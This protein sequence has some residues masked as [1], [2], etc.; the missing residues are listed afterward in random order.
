MATPVRSGSGLGGR[1]GSG[2]G[3]GA[4]AISA[5]LSKLES[6]INAEAEGRILRAAGL[7]AKSAALSAAED[8]LGGDRAMSNYK[9]GSVALNAGFDTK[10]WQLDINH[11]P[12]GLWLLADEGRKRSGAIYPRRNGR[13]ARKATKGRAVLTP[14][15]PRA[16]SSFKPSRGTNVFKTASARERDKASEAAWQALQGEIR[17]IVRG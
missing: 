6:T 3:F 7:A 11:R 2:A 4:S 5:Y 1:A 10:N 8:K 14:F 17:R 9:G 12:A 13:K 16:R 15:G